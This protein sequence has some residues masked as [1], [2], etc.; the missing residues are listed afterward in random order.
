[1]PTQTRFKSWVIT[2]NNY[3]PSCRDSLLGSFEEFCVYGC[4][5][6]EIGDSGTRHLQGFFCLTSP[7]T[8]LGVKRSLLSGTDGLRAAHLEPARGTSAQ[9]RD[10]CNKEE[11]RDLSAEFGFCEIGTFADC[12]GMP[13]QGQR[14]DLNRLSGLIVEGAQLSEV[15]AADPSSWVKFHRG[16]ESLF[17]IHNCRSRVWS[18]DAGFPPVHVYWFHGPTGTGKTREVYEVTPHDELYVKPPGDLWFDGY[19]N[20]NTLL[21]DD[22]RT[23]FTF[24]YLLNLLDRYPIRVPVKGSYVDV[25]WEKVYITAPNRPEEMYHEIAEKSDGRMDQL[26]RRITEIRRFGEAPPPES[27]FA[28]GFVPF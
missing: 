22:Y 8:L 19:V 1:M 5:Q 15:A 26:L 9:A 27:P 25:C 28:A 16:F 6:P 18:P 3:G 21:L 11:S 4:F 2:V 23:W 12:P 20:Q 14:T 17:R 13:G 24:G 10:Y 7:R